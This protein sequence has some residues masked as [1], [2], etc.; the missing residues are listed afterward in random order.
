MPQG[1]RNAILLVLGLCILFGAPRVQAFDPPKDEAGP[2]RVSIEGPSSI[3]DRESPVTVA[4]SIENTAAAALEGFVRLGLIDGWRAEPPDATPFAVAAKGQTRSLFSVTLPGD[5]YSAHYP[6]H[7][8]VEFEWEGQRQTAHPILIAETRFPVSPVSR[9]AAAWRPYP[10]DPHSRLGLMFLSAYRALICGKDGAVEVMAPGWQGAHPVSRADL[11]IGGTV[12]RGDARDAVAMHPAWYGGQTGPILVEFPLSLPDV[13]PIHL[14]FANAIRD[15]FPERGEPPS[16]G[17]TFRVRV[18]PYDA[19]DGTLGSIVFERHSASKTWEDGTADLSGFAG[20]EVRIQ[21]E[22]HPGPADDTTCDGCYWAEPTLTVGTPEAVPAARGAPRRLGTV[23]CGSRLFEIEAA[24]G[25]RGLLDADIRFRDGGQSIAFH[26]FRVRALGYRLDDPHSSCALTRVDDESEG[27]GCRIRHRFRSEQGEFDWV[28]ELVVEGGALRA[29]FRLEGA[30][31]PAPWFA[32]RIEELAL[33]AWTAEATRVYAG[34]GNVVE[35]PDSFNL[36][37]DG[38]HLASSFVGFDF[39]GGISVVQAVDT[40]PDKLMVVPE[41]RYYSLHTPHDQTLTLIP[42]A[43]VWEAVKVWREIDSRSAA[44]GVAGLAGRFVFDLWGGHYGPSADALQKAF[45]Y[46]LTDAVVVWHAW[47]RWGYDY[48][49]PDI[50]PPNPHLGAHEEFR[51]LA[52]ICKDHGVLFAPHD[53]YIDFYP[54]AEGFSYDHIVFNADGSPQRGW[55]NQGRSAQAYRFRPDRF[56]PFLERNLRLIRDDFAPTAYFIDVWSSMGPHD[57]WTR[58]GTFADRRETRRAWGEA[59]AWIRDF[60][61]GNAPQISESGHDQLIGRLD[62]AQ[63]NHL[64]WGNAATG[65]H[66]PMVWDF[67]AKDGERIPWLDAAYHDRFVLHGAGYEARYCSGLDPRLHGMYSDDY[68]TAEVLTGHPAMV[69]TVF[70]RNGVRKYW[71]L[72][73]LMRAL[74]LRQIESVEFVENDI[75]RQRVRWENGDIWVNRG[76]EDWRIQGA[77]LPQYGFLARVESQAGPVEAAIERRD[78]VIV[79]RASSPESLFVNARPARAEPEQIGVELMD[80]SFSEPGAISAAFRWRVDR[81]AEDG[82]H[83]FVHFVN[84]NEDIVFQGDFAP[85]TPTGQWKGTVENS[86]TAPIPSG[87]TAGDVFE[88]RAGLYTPGKLRRVAVGG[89]GDGRGA[90]RLA[91]VTLEGDKEDIKGIAWEPVRDPARADVEERVNI[92]NK[93]IGFAALTTDGGFRLTREGESIVATPL[94]ESPQCFLRIRWNELPWEL[95]R[96]VLVVSLNESGDALGRAP[97]Q[98]DGEEI[99]LVGEAGVFAYRLNR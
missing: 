17:V 86:T 56:T 58:E 69:D 23:S 67:G 48:R 47:Q 63:A 93:A 29:A 35:A 82:L 36:H 92:E 95:P 3:T 76:R 34:V 2:L 83:V 52:E 24:L 60:L 68:M 42:A 85:D 74:A 13:R 66:G 39:P 28:S 97:V 79:E 81:P 94:P 26:G 21:L 7:A 59:F 43:D 71:L 25:R 27:A 62:G 89:L 65:P 90:V 91:T 51:R 9:R 80:V 49:L 38:H 37:Y 8:W 73:D 16:D 55:L 53:N 61:G 98:W 41:R 87:C 99:L 84:Q 20:R 70:S 77:V 19:P 32:P 11:R 15:H 6:I 54:D 45:R 30:P 78:G 10:V 46:G 22:A 1:L 40:P 75:H 18:A 50:Y 72:H 31:A 57:F 33:G 4:V 5:C 88:L 12:H 14:E 96:P 64:R 44:G